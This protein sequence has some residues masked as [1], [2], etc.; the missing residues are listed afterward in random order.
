M[1]T[2]AVQILM[3]GGKRCGKSTVLSSMFSSINDALSGTDFVIETDHAT[4]AALDEAK[5]VIVNKMKEFANPLTSCEVEENPNP[6]E[7]PFNFR[8]RRKS[9]GKIKGSGIPFRIIDIPG[10]WLTNQNV[11]KVKGLIKDSQI[12][13]IAIDT[14]YLFAKMTDRG[15]GKYHEEANKPV[16]ITTFFKDVV[17]AKDLRDRMILFVPIKCERYYHLDKSMYLRQFGRSYMREV[18]EA[19]LKGYDALITYLRSDD[20]IDNQ[21][22]I[23]V[24]PILSA[25]GI[26]FISFRKNE[27]E[28]KMVSYYQSPEFLP[29]NE[30][31]YNPKFCEQ[32]LIYIL[33]YLLN[34]AIEANSSSKN[35]IFNRSLFSG[36][37]QQQMESALGTIKQKM[38]KNTGISIEEDGYFIFPNSKNL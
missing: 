16:Q 14:P 4:T 25:G 19:V 11:E 8:L 7:R 38:K 31:G 21:C 22:A 30:R 12:I 23:A 6:S 37:N 3:L 13:V 27:V 10:E 24:T 15:Y 18:T 1:N 5:A 28:D 36:I 35:S 2:T 20:E 17:P 34:S 32:P 29:A 26:D 9:N 33:V